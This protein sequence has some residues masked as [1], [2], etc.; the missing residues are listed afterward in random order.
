MSRMTIGSRPAVELVF[1]GLWPGGLRRGARDV[2][3]AFVGKCLAL[4]GSVGQRAFALERSRE[5]ILLPFEER[6]NGP[7]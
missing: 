6:A 4:L 3:Q 5:V 2:G 7:H 1:N